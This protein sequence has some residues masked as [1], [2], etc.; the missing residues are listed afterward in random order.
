MLWRSDRRVGASCPAVVSWF[1]DFNTTFYNLFCLKYFLIKNKLSFAANA[2]QPVSVQQP[3]HVQLEFCY[4]LSLWQLSAQWSSSFFKKLL[5]F[6]R[7]WASSVSNKNKNRREKNLTLVARV[8][9]R[10]SG[11]GTVF[12]TTYKNFF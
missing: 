4:V 6:A 8:G 10:L 9:G 11:R 7:M 3:L 12:S 5:N 2:W 1:C